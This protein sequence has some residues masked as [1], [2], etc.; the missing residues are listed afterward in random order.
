MRRNY[1]LK[2]L[3]CLLGLYFI[4]RYL[5]I[6]IFKD[7]KSSQ[8]DAATL[9]HQQLVDKDSDI[10]KHNFEPV[11]QLIDP[12]D[13]DKYQIFTDNLL[14]KLYSKYRYYSSKEASS[15][16]NSNK[17][18]INNNKRANDVNKEF[19]L[20]LE[21]TKVFH[22]SKYC[23]LKL[24]N[25]KFST[26]LLYKYIYES[27]EL[28][29]SKQD[30]IKSTH[31][32][33]LL[34]DC[35]YTN[36]FFTCDKNLASYSDA[37]LF[38]E[39]DLTYELQTK[40][41]LD[42]EKIIQNQQKL[43]PLNE[44]STSQLWLLWNDEA[45]PV[46]N[47]LDIF[48]FN[49][50]ISYKTV[51][52]VSYGAYGVYKYKSSQTTNKT[53]F[54][55]YVNLEFNKRANKII[56]FNSNCNSKLRINFA[57]NMSKNYPVEVFGKCNEDMSVFIKHQA[58]LSSSSSSYKFI[59]LNSTSCLR[60]SECEK[61]ILTE[62]KF[63][64]AFESKN[65]SYYITEKFWRT[66][67]SGLIPIVLQP[68]KHFYEKIAP[69]NSYIHLEDFDYNLK[70]L[71]KHLFQVSS[72]IDLYKTYFQWKYEYEVVYDMKL[73]KLRMCELCSKLNKETN[74]IYY[75]SVSN[76]FNNDCIVN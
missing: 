20:I 49:W 1:R 69:P 3:L 13:Y 71:S 47:V 35:L 70:K 2:F 52:E 59:K 27:N 31:V 63:Y 46:S 42:Y 23:D 62:N 16:L 25:K 30:K 64:L 57:L 26:H 36:C 38:H 65:C 54:D 6:P 29:N 68:S 17:L 44:R 73:E 19:Y 24:Q 9:L 72:S 10:V 37:I 7:E 40:Y 28:A 21:Y 15:L 43:T 41:G 14:N 55:D 12:L 67:S 56:W 58:K 8:D 66:L 18:E 39:T 76:Y 11:K 74:E 53:S 60:D 50:T 34:D 33:D 45:N 22:S 51:S 75:K 61:Q 4:I 48:N 5:L 32:Y